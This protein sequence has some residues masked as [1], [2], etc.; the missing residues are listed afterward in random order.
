MAVRAEEIADRLNQL[1]LQ[2][3][4]AR[5]CPV[6]LGFV[7]YQLEPQEDEDPLA[8]KIGGKPVRNQNYEAIS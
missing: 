5:E 1:Q 6:V 4:K 2:E 8:T 3:D 7:G